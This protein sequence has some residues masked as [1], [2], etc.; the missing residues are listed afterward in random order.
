MPSYIAVR[1]TLRKMLSRRTK[2]AIIGFVFAAG[3]IAL[4]LMSSAR[5]FA[6]LEE[7]R[8][9][10]EEKASLKPRPPQVHLITRQSRSLKRTLSA[11]LEPWRRV[12]L[13]PEVSGSI[14][15]MQAEI[16]QPVVQGQPLVEIDSAVPVATLAAAEARVAESRRL[17]EEI[18][19][20]ASRNV[21][22]KT[23]LE[24][25]AARLT[26]AE[27]ELAQARET[28]ALHTICAPF[29]GRISSKFAERGDH[30]RP[31]TP[32]IEVVD[33]SKLRIVFH[34]AEHEAHA[35][36]PGKKVEVRAAQKDTKPHQATIQFVAAAADKNTHL[37]RIEAVLD[38]APDDVLP[39]QQAVVAA[40]IVTVRDALFVPASALRYIGSQAFVKK[41]DPRNPSQ[42]KLVPVMIGEEMD[43][44]H[45]VFEGLSES[46]AILLQ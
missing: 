35:F 22:A 28:L 10:L 30:A 42:G 1:P 19:T 7:K 23:D 11:T 3:L 32:L 21:A 5:Y 8:R 26:I 36:P 24:A 9:Y 33:A 2:R 25:A 31:G 38:P 41:T 29:D 39:G 44:Q 37:V 40:D 16:G 6:A 4:I 20:L 46:D 13:A 43:G 17:L 34:V 45:V 14:T 18:R 12:T 27:A 15:T